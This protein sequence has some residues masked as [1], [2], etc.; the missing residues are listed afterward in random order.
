MVEKEK[1]TQRERIIEGDRHSEK[2]ETKKD[3]HIV[4]N[5][6]RDRDQERNEDIERNRHK[7]REGE[8]KIESHRER[9]LQ[10]DILGDRESDRLGEIERK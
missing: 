5:E 10:R 3:T 6:E 9:L 7:K 2:R 1:N 4:T 8:T